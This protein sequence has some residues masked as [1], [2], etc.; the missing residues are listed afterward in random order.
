MKKTLLLLLACFCL[1]AYA[2]VIELT[3]T[4]NFADPSSL[5]PKVTP[6]TTT[7]GVIPLDNTTFTNGAIKLSFG[8]LTP[9][10]LPAQI[11]TYVNPY[12]QE[13]SYY[14][15]INSGSVATF[16]SEGVVI[17]SIQFY[18]DGD[19]GTYS[20]LKLAYANEPGSVVTGKW[21]PK[22]GDAPV[23][24]V[25]FSSNAKSSYISKV[26]VTYEQTSILLV[27]SEVS[28]TNGDVLSS[29]QSMS[30]TF[31]SSMTAQS[32][33]NNITLT[34]NYAN[35]EEVNEKLVVTGNGT[36]TIVLS[37]ADDNKIEKDGSF[38]ID[39]PAQSFRDPS[40][41]ENVAL[42]Y[43]FTV[44]EPRDTFNPLSIDP[45]TTQTLT[46]L[47]FPITLQFPNSLVD[48][49]VGT[50]DERKTITLFYLHPEL[51]DSTWIE[52]APLKAIKGTSGQVMINDLS[53]WGSYQDLGLYKIEIPDSVVFNQ[54]TLG[55]P[56]SRH[57]AAL[58]LIYT[59]AEP[60]DP[61]KAKKDSV[62]MLV[63]EV[64]SLLN[65][66][67][68]KVGYPQESDA[69]NAVKD[70]K[71]EDTD[72]ETSLSQKIESLLGA[73]K[74]FYNDTNVLL[75]EK[76][77]WYTISSVNKKDERLYL[78][79]ANG[80]V[81]L[82]TKASP[83]K[84]NDINGNVAVFETADGKFLHVLIGSN[85]Y[86]LTSTSNVTN[87]K[88][89]VNDL[90]LGKMTLAGEGVD[91]KPVAGLFTIR[92]GLGLDKTT[93][94]KVGDA[95]AL[96]IH[97]ETPSIATSLKYTKFYFENDSTSAFRFA[98]TVGPSDKVSPWA[99][100]KNAVLT[101]N[102]QVMTLEIKGKDN[103]DD[104]TK[105]AL[106]SLAGVK[107]TYKDGDETK[108]ANTTADPI[109]KK[110]EDGDSD[111]LFEVHVD[112]LAD[113]TY[114]LV[115]PAGTFDFS[116]N[117]KTVEDTDLKVSFKIEST[118]GPGPGPDDYAN[119]GSLP[120][121]WGTIPS[122]IQGFPV[123]DTDLLEVYYYVTDVD[124]YPNKDAAYN[125]VKLCERWTATLIV[126]GHFEPVYRDNQHMLK[127]VYEESLADKLP[128]ATGDYT[129][130]VGRAA[131][132]DEN[133]NKRQN[134]DTSIPESACRVN[135]RVL[136]NNLSVDNNITGVI[137]N[138]NLSGEKGVYFDLQGRRVSSP[139][140]GVYIHNGKK[141]VIK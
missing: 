45:D 70:F 18:A 25:S 39:I 96:V 84:V 50:V 113:N 119:Y 26:V 74:T 4:F 89:Y 67:V 68:G 23:T 52:V 90:T 130:V 80:A 29:F 78:T 61:L 138:I 106:K 28:L 76:D 95:Y 75:P 35:G 124:V 12:S 137:N 114:T 62:V 128:L 63:S 115:L 72:D 140:K 51:T 49:R 81:T 109:L 98:E 46:E 40:G 125:V 121:M 8:R 112:G 7:G 15:R 21:E 65:N 117:P 87:E 5:N 82:G 2:N 91:Q 110:I 16:S 100:I 32:A 73:L 86:D 77:K 3:A 9:E 79:Y 111:N 38:A 60:A 10:N 97:G 126:N 116:E 107:F 127:I 64:D 19:M 69:L 36:K 1:T 55:Y 101:S 132:G 141:V 34:G 133:F 88:K 139:T 56:S 104:V 108:D 24:H 17:K 118:P 42:H 30:L 66:C 27:P 122:L 99:V 44:R 53:E 94:E 71:V 131:Y 43:T 58:D 57:N 6:S 129:L 37:L 14:L 83:F 135:Q 59:V 11:A 136:Y 123:V 31:V 102:T 105:V 41:Y 103:D 92:G 47:T 33:A 48:G 93:S 85:D 13:T 20:P 22:A 134:G 120:E 54:F